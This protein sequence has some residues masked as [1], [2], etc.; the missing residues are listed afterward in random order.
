MMAGDWLQG[1]YVYALYS[2]YGFTQEEIAVYNRK[3]KKLFC[4]DFDD[5]S[6]RILFKY[7]LRGLEKG[8]GYIL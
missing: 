5:F 1:P 6:S 3:K 2:S 7:N 4:L 8:R